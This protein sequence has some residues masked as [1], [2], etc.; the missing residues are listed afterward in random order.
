MHKRR[1][2]HIYSG[3]EFFAFPC[4]LAVILVRISF[5]LRTS[6]Y[7]LF[8]VFPFCEKLTYDGT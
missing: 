7:R 5:A 4:P 2:L 3:A 6:L 8:R 1:E